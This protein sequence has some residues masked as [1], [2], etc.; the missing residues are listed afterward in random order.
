MKPVLLALALIGLLAEP[1][2]AFDPSRIGL[3]VTEQDFEGTADAAREFAEHRI[4]DVRD[5]G[6]AIAPDP[7]GTTKSLACAALRAGEAIASIIIGAAYDA[8]RALLGN[9]PA[10]PGP[11]AAPA[12]PLA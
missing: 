12:C 7:L 6:E 5:L 8:E 9:D 2:Q 3:P 11:P 10:L 4:Q 1:A